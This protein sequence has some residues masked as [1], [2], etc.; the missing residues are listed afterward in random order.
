MFKNC[1]N[2]TSLNNNKK[3]IN[4]QQN[5]IQILSM[6]TI[7]KQTILEYNRTSFFLIEQVNSISLRL[8]AAQ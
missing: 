3:K 2:R 7:M 6:T 5:Y 8:T 1:A 4:M